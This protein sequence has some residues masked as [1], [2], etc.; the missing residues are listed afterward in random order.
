MDMIYIDRVP[1]DPSASGTVSRVARFPSTAA[2]GGAKQ[3]LAV[4]CVSPPLLLVN[5][6]WN[7]HVCAV[8][9]ILQFYDGVE[10]CRIRVP[11]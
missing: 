2:R 9:S 7:W 5:Q 1:G 6:Q 4:I 3:T 11:L 10:R 8:L